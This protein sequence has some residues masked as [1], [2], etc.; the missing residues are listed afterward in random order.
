MKLRLYILLE[1]RKDLIKELHES[2]EFRYL[3]IKEIV[4]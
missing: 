2:K 3:S 1:I 4:R